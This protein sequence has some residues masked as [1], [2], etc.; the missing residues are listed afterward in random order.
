MSLH[1]SIPHPAADIRYAPHAQQA[2]LQIKQPSRFLPVDD[3][4]WCNANLPSAVPPIFRET[5]AR[6]TRANAYKKNSSDLLR[7]DQGP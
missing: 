2:S 4:Y 1:S 6:L 3:Y 7:S 5:I